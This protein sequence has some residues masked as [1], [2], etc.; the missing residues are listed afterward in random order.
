MGGS[1]VNIGM[2]RLAGSNL[3][4]TSQLSTILLAVSTILVELM[5]EALE[6]D[7]LGPSPKLKLF[8]KHRKKHL[9]KH[10][11]LPLWNA[12]LRKAMESSFL[13]LWEV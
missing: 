7:R 8:L 10:T 1:A 13:G 9:S 2:G 12:N 3:G 5:T 6:P 11:P 4:N